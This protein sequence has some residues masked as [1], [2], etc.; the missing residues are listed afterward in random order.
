VL[1]VK[2]HTSIIKF[3]ILNFVTILVMLRIFCKKS[4]KYKKPTGVD[5]LRALLKVENIDK[6][7]E[8]K[9]TEVIK[10]IQ[11]LKDVEL[12]VDAKEALEEIK[13]EINKADSVKEMIKVLKEIKQNTE[14]DKIKGLRKGLEVSIAILQDGSASIYSED[15]PYTVIYGP[16]QV[17]VVDGGAAVGGALAGIGTGPGAV[18]TGVAAGVGASTAQAVSDFID[19][20]F[21]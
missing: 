21:D 1:E 11:N 14:D 19:W 16:K 20:L 4:V 3:T 15:S 5:I 10:I 17:A 18:A 6:N 7:M 9:I 13:R 2:D 8:T 12:P